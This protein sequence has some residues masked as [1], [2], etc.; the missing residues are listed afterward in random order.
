[1]NGAQSLLRT[2]VDAGVVV[3]FANPGTSEMHF[4]AVLDS[5]PEMRG[6]LGLFEGFCRLG[7]ADPGGHPELCTGTWCGTRQH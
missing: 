2:L 6:V 3:C 4:V 5:V 7:G 1:M